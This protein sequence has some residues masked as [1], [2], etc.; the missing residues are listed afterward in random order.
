M[1][2]HVSGEYIL[3]IALFFIAK[4][5]FSF[6]ITLIQTWGEGMWRFS[7]Y[8]YSSHLKGGKLV[9]LGW[10]YKPGEVD[11]GPCMACMPECFLTGMSPAPLC[12]N[13]VMGRLRGKMK[14]LILTSTNFSFF[15]CQLF[16]PS[17]T[18]L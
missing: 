7:A 2:P 6:F 1:Y 13:F 11:V 3:L 15:L 5:P 4:L 16:Y 18:F 9:C 8:F 14:M 12:R 17:S 10:G